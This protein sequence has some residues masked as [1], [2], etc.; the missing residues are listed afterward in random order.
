MNN[1][2]FLKAIAAFTALPR[3][4]VELATLIAA[5]LDDVPRKNLYEKLLIAEARMRVLKREENACVLTLESLMH[6]AQKDVR[7]IEETYSKSHDESEVSHL[8]SS[9]QNMK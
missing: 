7:T 2:S 9:I 1:T 5:G 4:S 3:E 8:E 6:T